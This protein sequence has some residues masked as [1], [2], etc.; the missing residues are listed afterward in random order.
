MSSYGLAKKPY[1]VLSMQH[2]TVL[3]NAK[4]RMWFFRR[5]TRPHSLSHCVGPLPADH[6]QIPS[7]HLLLV[8]LQ[9]EMAEER[10]SLVEMFR[11]SHRDPRIK[12]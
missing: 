7:P 6:D 10:S 11:Y 4:V 8:M 1:H 9:P 2:N 3:P 12:L 5:Y